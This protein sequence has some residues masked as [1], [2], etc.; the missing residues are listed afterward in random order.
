MNGCCGPARV[1]A[2]V[3]LEYA[4]PICGDPGRTVNNITVKSLVVPTLL[5]D[6]GTEDYNICLNPE[7]HIVYYRPGSRSFSKKDLTV[8]VSYK[9][10]DRPEIVCYCHN[11]TSDDVVN[12]MRQLPQLRDFGEVQRHFGMNDC[13]C[14][15]HHPF[16][17]NCACASAVG[18]AVKRGHADPEVQAIRARRSDLPKVVVYERS[19]GCCGP[20]PG[21]QLVDSLNAKASERAEVS[22]VEMAGAGSVSVSPDLVHAM[23]EKGEEALPAV[24]I[25]D[26]LVWLGSCPATDEVLLYLL[27]M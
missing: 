19:E 13:H 18:R 22:R 9:E 27:K 15:K 26:H 1:Q 16:G 24:T 3:R 6:M 7:C 2:P 10:R 14:E 21:L 17:G 8:P 4:C 11:L 5:E 25:N 20:S 12:A 23:M